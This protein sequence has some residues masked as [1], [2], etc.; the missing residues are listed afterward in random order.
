MIN[1]TNVI[2]LLTQIVS[3]SHSNEF[4]LTENLHEKEL[5]DHLVRL[6]DNVRLSSSYKISHE[7]TFDYNDVLLSG[8]QEHDKAESSYNDADFEDI[9]AGKTENNSSNLLRKLSLDYMQKVLDYL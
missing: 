2:R 3:Q 9:D 4:T 8:Q 1:T 6:I 5:V 7:D